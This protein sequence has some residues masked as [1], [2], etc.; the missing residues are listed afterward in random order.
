MH[1]RYEQ[2]L[3]YPETEQFQVIGGKKGCN[4]LIR[5]IVTIDI[6]DPWS[7]INYGD[8]V[9]ISG[10]AIKDIQAD[11]CDMIKKLQEKGGAGLAIAMGRYILGIPPEVIALADELKFPLMIFP[12]AAKNSS[13]LTKIY[14]ELFLLEGGL[15]SKDK[16]MHDLICNDYD[17]IYENQMFILGYNQ[18]MKH[19]IIKIGVVEPEKYVAQMGLH[20]LRQLRTELD[21]IFRVEF[22]KKRKFYISSLEFGDIVA[23]VDVKDLANWDA[24]LKRALQRGLEAAQ[25]RFPDICLVVGGSNLFADLH[26]FREKLVEAE[27][28]VDNLR[29]CQRYNACRLY[30]DMGVYQ[31]FYAAEKTQLFQLFVDILGPL[32]ADNH[33]GDTVLLDTLETYLNCNMMIGDTAEKMFFHRNTVKNRIQQI[34]QLLDGDLNDVN[35]CF[36]LRLAFK[37]KRFLFPEIGDDNVEYANLLR[38]MQGFKKE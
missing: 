7:F 14:H 38:Y 37:I 17:P 13:I 21:D 35:Y 4:C 9:L 18:K 1:M 19:I 25:A 31:M 12:F 28:S 34:E 5:G 24:M 27:R 2:F 20:S 11:L 6:T 30:R 23:M 15:N 10:I 16:L 29:G 36:N 26:Q 32:L 33:E 3:G 22:E 8:I